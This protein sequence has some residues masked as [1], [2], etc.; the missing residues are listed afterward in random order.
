MIWVVPG[1]LELANGL[2]ALSNQMLKKGDCNEGLQLAEEA[3]AIRER[4][5][6]PSHPEV[7]ASLVA[8]GWAHEYGGRFEVARRCYE[9]VSNTHHYSRGAMCRSGDGEDEI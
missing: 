7:A 9:Q 3:Q 4:L 5:L 1:E 2:S 8:T 6:P